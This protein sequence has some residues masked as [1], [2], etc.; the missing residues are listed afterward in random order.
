[1]KSAAHGRATSRAEVSN[2]STHGF[3]LIVDGRELFLSFAKF[4]WFEAAAI[5][6]LSN[7]ELY[8]TEHL[9]W[10][11]LDVDLSVDSIEHPERY[12]L[13]FNTK[14]ASIREKSRP[15]P[16]KQRRSRGK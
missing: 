1:M 2:V 14:P 4:P 12:P 16:A 3:W 15:R 7:V 8:G 5:R 13:V 10:P 9:F 11:A 6:D